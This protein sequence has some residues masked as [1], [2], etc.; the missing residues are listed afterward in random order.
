[1]SR[2][3]EMID[4]SGSPSQ[5]VGQLREK[6]VTVPSWTALLK[7]YEPKMHKV[8]RDRLNLPDRRGGRERSSRI[9]IGLE[10]L[11]ARRMNEFT[12]AVPVRR[13]Y[14]PTD[15]ETLL[16][17]RRAIEAVYRCA[18]ID[19]ENLRRGLQYYAACECVTLWYTVERQNRLYGF[20]TPYKL[21]CRTYSPMGGVQLYPLIDDRGD[22]VAMSMEYIQRVLDRD[23]VYFETYTADR[24]YQWTG[25]KNSWREDTLAV[26]ADGSI[27]HGEEMSIGKIPCAYIW[28]PAPIWDGLCGLRREVEY[29]LSRNSNTIAYNAA[30]VLKISG[31]YQGPAEKKGQEQRVFRLENGGDVDYVE[32][33]QATDAVQ[34]HVEQMLKLFWQQSQMPDISFEAM[35][36]LGNIG[37]DARQT[38][39][40]DAHLKVGDESGAWLEFLE[41]EFN[42]IKAFLAQMNTRWAD[43]MDEV[44]C[45]HVITPFIQR[46]E[47][48]E[49]SLRMKANGGKAIE[50]QRES[51]TK[52]GAHDVDQTMREIE[53]ETARENRSRAE[54]YSL[55]DQAY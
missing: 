38:L 2:I 49:I 31:E 18:H 55:N 30:P 52:Y 40:T 48:N 37:Y 14:E 54:A 42:I 15:D 43:R 3:D 45:R 6:S 10:K 11:L 8:N 53:E 7:E 9:H 24:H 5:T 25:T 28:R 34:Y 22:M 16:D 44:Q 17:I 20:D 33:T 19:A 12:F 36:A 46:N 29:T 1:M 21:R 32:W 41:R 50:S 39:L 47:E 13:Q 35:S 4:F 51:I 27:T 23:V 26:N